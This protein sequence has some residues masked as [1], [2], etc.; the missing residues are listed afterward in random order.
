MATSP[1]NMKRVLITGGSGFIGTNLVEY[2]YRQGCAVVNIDIRHPRNANHHALWKKCDILDFGHLRDT[3]TAFDPE[4]VIHLAARTDLDEKKDING[5]TANVDGVRNV[6]DAANDCGRLKRV[7]FASSRYVC[8][9][10][11]QPI[12]DED[13]SPFT[14]YGESKV[15]GEQIVRSA[16]VDFEWVIVRPTS[17]WGPWFDIPYVVFFETIWKGLYF[18][19]G[20][21]NPKKQ[22]GYVG[23]TVYQID[24][25]LNASDISVNRKTL[26]V[27]DYPPY[28]LTN[29]ADLI[30]QAMARKKIRSL[31]LWM[32]RIAALLGDRLSGLGWQKWPI[33]TSRL[34]NLVADI[35]YD[36]H[37]LESICGRLPYD[38]GT[39]VSTT[40]SW[41]R[42]VGRI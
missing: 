37:E 34:D 7:I 19:I 10:G 31:P 15:I 30:R 18:N 4:Y 26:Y 40:V 39:G 33:T 9:N 32:L 25:L 27:C 3:L 20:R 12:H 1:L 35:I 21:L 24:K 41:M 42:A 13:Y 29:W 22:Y 38:L 36:T 23:N 14:L 28:E 17:I 8:A 2:Y 5:Y 6:V 11:Y 16:E